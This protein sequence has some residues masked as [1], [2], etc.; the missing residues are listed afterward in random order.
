MTKCGLAKADEL[1]RS[2]EDPRKKPLI[3][4]FF[5]EKSADYG[6]SPAVIEEVWGTLE[7][8]SSFGFCKAHGAAFA[9]PTYQSAWLKTHYPTEF[10]AGL[11]THD[12]G[13]YPRRLLLAEARRLGVQILPL[14]VNKSTAEYRVETL[15]DGSLAVRLALT[16]IQNVSQNEIKR[17]IKNAPFKDLGDFYLRAEPSRRTLENLALLGA[18]DGVAGVTAESISAMVDPDSL[19]ATRGDVMAKVRQLNAVTKRPKIDPA[20][21]TLDFIDLTEMMP[22]GNPAPSVEENV[23]NELKLMKLDVSQHVIELY[24][25]MLDEMGVVRSDELV[26]LRNRTEVL[27]AGVRVA[28]QTPPMRSG[29]R[30]VF[31]SLDDGVGCADATFFDEAQQRC[32]HVLFNTRLVLVAGKTRRTGVR[33]VSI[34]AE[35]AWDLKDLYKQW[36]K[37]K[38]LAIPLE[39]QQSA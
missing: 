16:E 27:V 25:E 34:M 9:M 14:D 28:T 10:V 13:M 37:R 21:P 12:P 1:R 22:R 26:G 33:G 5:R 11:F 8:F 30:V 19:K 4:K 32:S 24:R 36:R 29:K 20:Q 23:L 31:I 38:E 15:P 6:Y 17:I 18:L 39:L 7:G 35:N 3:E 2:M